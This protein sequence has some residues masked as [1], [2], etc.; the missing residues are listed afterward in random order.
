M[1]ASYTQF[2]DRPQFDEV[3]KLAD[4]YIAMFLNGEIDRL[5]VVYT[6]FINTARQ[7]AVVRDLAADPDRRPGPRRRSP[8]P[9][10]TAGKKAEPKAEAVPY[11]YI[12]DAQGIIEEIVPV[13]FKVRLFKC[14][15]DAAVS[16]QIARMVAMRGATQNADDLVQ[17]AD[18]VVQ[19]G[20]AVADHPRAG[21]HR[22]RG[23]RLEVRPRPAR[24]QSTRP[25]STGPET[26]K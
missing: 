4:R 13:S 18:P 11:E 16:E 23:R 8:T 9:E 14:F 2:E 24:P 12:P 21:R 10:A 20:P 7:D 19:P 25:V 6:E 22:G 1:A 26:T 17:R 15:L 5:D 3:E